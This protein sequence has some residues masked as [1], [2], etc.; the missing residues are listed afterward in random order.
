MTAF[1]LDP[2]IVLTDPE[3]GGGSATSQEFSDLNFKLNRLLIDAD[4]D[5]V[6]HSQRQEFMEFVAYRRGVAVSREEAVL[7]DNGGSWIPVGTPFTS[8]T[9]GSLLGAADRGQ[10]FA[11][12]FRSQKGMGRILTVLIRDGLTENKALVG[13]V[14]SA[15][16]G[17]GLDTSECR[18]SPN[19]NS[20]V[21]RRFKPND[22]VFAVT[23]DCEEI[24]DGGYEED[25]YEAP[26]PAPVEFEPSL[27]D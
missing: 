16:L 9:L 2:R 5:P 25:R 1:R 24:D 7:I 17:A 18:I 15:F 19:A 23:I 11:A 8:S 22:V 10:E 12:W 3:R 21:A 27:S 14:E 4:L 20:S 26:T 6:S 13:L